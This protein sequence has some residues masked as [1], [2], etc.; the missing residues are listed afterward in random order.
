MKDDELISAIR[1]NSDLDD[2]DE[3]QRAA[4][5]TLTVLG[6]RLAGGEPL[7]LGSQLP[8]SFGES[9]AVVGEGERFSLD[10]FYDRVGRMEGTAHEDARRHARA[11]MAGVK[12]AV[13]RN[14]WEDMLAQL[15]AEYSDLVFTGPVH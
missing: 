13:D 9:L 10:E 7:D 4:H 8:T 3:V 12:A 5:A 1:T 15:P 14:E 11:V 6:Q 2:R